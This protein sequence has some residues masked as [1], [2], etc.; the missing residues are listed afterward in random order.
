MLL[1][2]VRVRVYIYIT[3]TQYLKEDDLFE[4][5]ANIIERSA[6]CTLKN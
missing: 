6:H 2:R 4:K 3:I 1:V 5:Y